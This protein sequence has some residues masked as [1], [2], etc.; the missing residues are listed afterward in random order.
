MKKLLVF[1]LI[2]FSVFSGAFVF[3]LKKKTA[4]NKINK[5][6]EAAIL[7]AEGDEIAVFAIEY[8]VTEAE[9]RKG[10]M[11]R[12]YLEPEKGMLFIYDYEQPLSFWMK[13]T[14]IP[15][16]I[17]YLNKEKKIVRIIDSA[18]P[19][20]TSICETYSSS[21]PCQYVLEINAGL[22]QKLGIK[23]D[24]TAVFNLP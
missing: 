24:Q 3:W 15:L 4:V 9:K 12:D 14:L 2:L 7:N 17:I 18:Q 8:A 16:D 5:G 21:A 10:L 19:C 11:E 22:S 1:I 20:R 13:N 6:P 23:V